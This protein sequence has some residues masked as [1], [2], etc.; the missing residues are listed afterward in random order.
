MIIEK[1]DDCFSIN[2]KTYTIKHPKDVMILKKILIKKKPI[3]YFYIGGLCYSKKHFCLT[4]EISLPFPFT[5][6][7]TLK[8]IDQNIDNNLCKSLIFVKLPLLNLQFD[9]EC[10]SIK[11]DPFIKIKD[12][13]I[14]PFISL[15]EDDDNY[16]VTFY[17]L[18]HFEVKEKKNA[19]L[20]FGKKKRISLILKNGDSFNF[21][22]STSLNLGSLKS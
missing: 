9:N 18:K 21:S 2:K 17:L 10:V 13:K 11:F 15:D 14:Y 6:Y 3:N 16:I 7:Y 4:N 19:W 5:S 22:I 12:K 8:I 1:D 20:G